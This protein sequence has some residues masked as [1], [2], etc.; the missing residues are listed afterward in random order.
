[1]KNIILILIGI[2]IILIENSIMNYIDIFNISLNASI[3][4]ISIISLFV[5]RNEGALI[6]LI[7]GLLKDILIG[8][9]I[10]VNALVFFV[11]GYLYGIL[12]DK[13]FKE[14][15]TTIFILTL[16]S[17]LFDSL[18]NCLLLK[19]SFESEKILFSLVKGTFFIPIL[20]TIFALIIYK[21]LINF[22]KKLDDI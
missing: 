17:S 21:A 12:Q 15:I 18:V 19:S 9:F 8:R 11:I 22:V 16:F 13:I 20:N 4:Y 2:F 14:N 3:V 7:L 10:G 6:G 1:M 5:K